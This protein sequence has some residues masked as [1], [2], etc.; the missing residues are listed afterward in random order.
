[1]DTNCGFSLDEIALAYADLFPLL[2]PVLTSLLLAQQHERK[3]W[4]RNANTVHADAIHMNTSIGMPTD[5]PI[6]NSGWPVMT[7]LKM[8]AMAVPI[9]DP[10]TVR[11]AAINVQM[12]VGRLHHLEKTTI[13]VAKIETKFMQMPV[14][15]APNI[16]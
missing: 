3:R 6:F 11:S 14:M 2:L 7:V 1:M 12:T 4:V 8:T 10:R 5:A 16:T 15:K 13:G 9:P